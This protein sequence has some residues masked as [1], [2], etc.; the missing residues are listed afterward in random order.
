MSGLEP[1]VAGGDP[2]GNGNQAILF[3]TEMISRRPVI[4]GETLFDEFER[5]PSVLG[6]APLN[7]AWNLCGFGL[8]PFFISAVG[9]D[10]RGQ[11]AKDVMSQWGL[12][13]RGIQTSGKFPT[14]TVQ[15]RVH[16]GNP[17]FEILD[18]QAWDDIRLT[19]LNSDQSDWAL[20]YSGSLAFRNETSQATLRQL[21][22]TAAPRFVDINIRQPFFEPAWLEELL[23]G[24]QW[25]KLNHEELEFVC[26]M[27]CQS[28]EQIRVAIARLREQ[29]CNTEFLVTCG[30]AG[31]VAIDKS[32]E[33]FFAAAPA[34]Q[35]LIDSVGAGDAFSAAT[36]YGLL[37]DIPLQQV[38]AAAVHFASRTC[39]F[40]GALT[41]NRQH[42]RDFTERMI[43]VVKSAHPHEGNDDIEPDGTMRSHG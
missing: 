20:F 8:D 22:Q 35:P 11:K 3:D 10:S 25:V 1:R 18:N 32:G 43:P 13:I 5:G 42:Y 31:A 24:A 2:T 9:N 27:T 36:I 21:I 19:N 12:D 29:Y 39:S 6:G 23:D 37:H 38:L 7:V 17:V 4:A 33:S 14:G 30:S 15:V 26:G 40:V 41:T 34:P 28:V 16:N